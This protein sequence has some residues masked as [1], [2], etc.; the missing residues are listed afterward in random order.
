MDFCA[1]YKAFILNYGKLEVTDFCAQY[2]VFIL[3]YGK[4]K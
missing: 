1:Q 3:H 4:L 2:K